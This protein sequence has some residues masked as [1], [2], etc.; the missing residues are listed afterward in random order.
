MG[1]YEPS[2]NAEEQTM[3]DLMNLNGC[4]VVPDINEEDTVIH[5]IKANGKSAHFRADTS[6]EAVRKCFKFWSSNN[7]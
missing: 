7:D 2:W 5:L 3:V 1:R 4:R 6:Y